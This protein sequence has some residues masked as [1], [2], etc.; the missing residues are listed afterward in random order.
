MKDIQHQTINKYQ[1]I[2]IANIPIAVSRL[3]N[4]QCLNTLSLSTGRCS[5]KLEISEQV[6]KD[7]LI[8]EF[9]EWIEAYQIEAVDTR[10]CC[11]FR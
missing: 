6:N 4:L 3:V 9:S 2:F 11:K 10:T 1:K 5:S 8:E 7:C